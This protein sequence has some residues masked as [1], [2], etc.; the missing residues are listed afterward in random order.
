MKKNHFREIGKAFSSDAIF[1]I[2]GIGA[3]TLSLAVSIALVGERAETTIIQQQTEIHNIQAQQAADKLHQHL[4]TRV[5]LL[6]DLA[7]SPSIISGV[8]GSSSNLANL[9]DFLNNYRFLGKKEAI[10]ITDILGSI[11]YSDH[12]QNGQSKTSQVA[13][14]SWFQPLLEGS[15]S[16]VVSDY[17]NPNTRN[18]PT[19]K[20]AIP[21]TY[22]NNNEGVLSVYF[23]KPI[24]SLFLGAQDQAITLTGNQLNYSSKQPQLDY[25]DIQTIPI[26][27]FDISITYHLS[28]ESITAE[29]KSFMQA[30][31]LAIISSLG[32]TFAILL[33]LGKKIIL[34]PFK[35]LKESEQALKQE[36]DRNALFAEAI[37]S[38]PVGVSIADA[39]RLDTPLVYTNKA[40]TQ[41]TGYSKDDVLNQN[42]RFL[43]GEETNPDSIEDIRQ[44]IQNKRKTEVELLNYKKDGTPFW[45]T[46]Q[47]SP[48]FDADGN[49]KAYVGVQQDITEKKQQESYLSGITQESPSLLSYI[50]KDEKYLFAN[51]AYQRWFGIEPESLHGR[52]IGDRL[53]PEKY[54]E[55][56]P[57]IQRAL[58]GET[59]NLETDLAGK[60]NQHYQVKITY[61]PHFD[62]EK[63]VK[64]FF[65][66]VDDITAFK[67]TE[68]I[69]EKAR[70]NAEAANTAKSQFLA[71]MSHEIRTPMNGVLGMLRLL[72]NTKLNDEQKHRLHLAKSSAQSLLTLINDILDFSKID[73]GKMDIE[74]IDFDLRGVI[75]D[76]AE[77]AAAQA[78]E[79]EID[80]VLDNTG[81]DESL[82][83]GDPGRIRQVITNI[84]GNAIKF[85]KHGQ[86]TILSK[87]EPINA[88]QYL[89]TCSISDTGIGIP[90]DNIEKLFD[91][92]T[93]VDASTTR[94][95]G[96]TGL[97]LS[98]A[99]KLCKLMQG[100][101][102]VTS[103]LNKGSQFTC[104]FILNKSLN[105]QQGIV[106]PDNSK[107]LNILI[108]SE[109]PSCGAS[110]QKQFCHWGIKAETIAP[111]ELSSINFEQDSP[112]F[113]TLLIDEEVLTADK[114]KIAQTLNLLPG[115]SSIHIVLMR[116]IDDKSSTSLIQRLNIDSYFPKP[117]TQ[118][119]LV[120]VIDTAS[121][122]T[123][124]QSYFPQEQV[125]TDIS[126]DLSEATT[127]DNQHIRLLLVEDNQI[128]QFVAV[129]ILEDLGFPLVDIAGNGIEAISSLKASIEETPYQLILMDCQMPE[130][131]GYE[132][133]QAIRTG[134]A[135]EQFKRIPIVAMTAN[136]MQGD[137]ERC[138]EA[139]MNDYLSKPIDP[140]LLEEK[141]QQ[142][143][144]PESIG[145]QTNK[146][147][148]TETE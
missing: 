111:Q 107:N 35:K 51:Q 91:S 130:M 80:L 67:E 62:A 84:V 6:Q 5:K 101:I 2:F 26:S 128:N 146:G 23:S 81:I 126:E 131:D 141:L 136:A 142:W 143:L 4:D 38:S 144:K 18:G 11:I 117:A 89:Y 29:K 100:D 95:Y 7:Q 46:L 8:M 116:K 119:N 30:I 58:N 129:D 96:G 85:T 73:A 17:N 40:F 77:S 78:H 20:I 74:E 1:Y 112:G 32:I 92:F 61:T 145:T 9:T 105:S 13:E 52:T 47:I 57:Y 93:Q 12:T 75:E 70:K 59:V 24:E 36:K 65:V 64:G 10:I 120:A 137:R 140:D 115:R 68:R 34:N 127:L 76:Y 69:Q 43:Q 37:E 3:F 25:Q 108:C 48:V 79:K 42:C 82:V 28:S 60:N 21:I 121:N 87:L 33:V 72:E 109:N 123:K 98:I 22:K 134:G 122:Q 114:N 103:E 102:Q 124:I 135:G 55:L 104:T 110:I 113:D 90:K 94:K 71:S 41:I 15:L 139:G 56:R 138:L 19:F 27:P 39:N 147:E 45:N 99:K 31:A 97:G 54:K 63:N 50:D 86:V 49:I 133:T 132:A 44:A 14:S 53:G 125:D 88:S 148:H 83:C 106:L 118:K 66:S 16:M